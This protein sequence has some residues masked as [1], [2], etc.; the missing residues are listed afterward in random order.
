[1]GR[2]NLT[3]HRRLGVLFRD[4]FTCLYCGQIFLA[5]KLTVDHLQPVSKGG[6]NRP[7]NLA[8]CCDE[9][10]QIKGDIL[11]KNYKKVY[12]KDM[13]ARRK[14]SEGRYEV[15]IKALIVLRGRDG[16]METM[17]DLARRL[18]RTARFTNG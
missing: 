4:D 5:S 7:R 13:K 9:C 14:R 16:A 17:D 2:N 12:G 10:N 8:A 18:K 11:W 6:S 3:F 1:M 15:I